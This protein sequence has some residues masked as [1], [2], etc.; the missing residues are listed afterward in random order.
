MNEL[1]PDESR[2]TNS[3]QRKGSTGPV[4]PAGRRPRRNDSTGTSEPARRSN[5]GP[6]TGHDT[7]ARDTP[8]PD[9]VARD[10]VARQTV[11]PNP[12]GDAAVHGAAATNDP[13]GAAGAA[14]NA[15]QAHVVRSA[16]Q[17]RSGEELGRS[18]F[19]C[20]V[21]VGSADGIL[22]VV[23]HLL[24]FHPTNSLVVLGIGGAHARIRLAFRYD[25][26]DPPD[27]ALAADIAA[28]A[29]T[30]LD[31][32]HLSLAIIVGY[33][34]GQ[35]VTGVVDVV[36]PTLHEA[37][38]EIQ[39]MLRVHNGRY[40][41]YLCADLRCCPAE[42]RPYDPAGHPAAAAL[43]A[44]GLAARASRDDLVGSLARDA[45]SIEPMA[46]AI[47]R[48]RDRGVQ[49]IEQSLTVAGGSDPLQ[50]VA[51]AGRR[52]VRQAVAL[53][54]R[55]G[56]FAGADEAAWLGFTLVDLRVR[57]DAWA[58]M[59]AA[60]ND[61]HQRLWTHL[62]RR[63]PADFVA[64]PASLLAFTAWQSG[65][66]ALASIAVERALEADPEYSMALLIADAL[67]AGLPPSA[68]RL[69]MTP[70]QVAASYA[71]HRKPAA[72]RSSRKRHAQP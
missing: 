58:R 62:I 56:E 22:A 30:V 26:P 28:H 13:A 10:T 69:P 71:K 38:I 44:A 65:D 8:T 57:D 39:D 35:A 1:A 11:A 36:A 55:G 68:A 16:A 25:L 7:A 70:K 66:G 23:P 33:G 52:A 17:A 46:L 4:G 41:S 15:G 32:E 6:A 61:A 37:R 45:E 60:F 49:L 18:G 24:G 54:R 27:A 59:D 47:E 43:N 19:R 72:A 67:H 53:Y 48:A 2:T 34:D 31:R 5:V 64:A 3:G 63:L 12:A 50:S 14:R 9:T 20:R 51:D 40:W 29:A 21:R 42:G